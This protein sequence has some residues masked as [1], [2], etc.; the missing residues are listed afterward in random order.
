MIFEFAD[1]W[2]LLLLILVPFLLFLKGRA[3]SKAALRFPSTQ[4]AAQ[5]AAFV[6]S[7]PGRWR[8]ALRWLAFALLVVAMARPQTGEEL[9]RT[10]SSGIDMVIA[11]DL[12]SSMWAHD[13]EIDDRPVDRLTVVREVVTEFIENR[14]NDRIGLI[15]FAAQPYMVSP[16][17]LNHD[18][19]LRRLD[20]LSIGEIEDGTAIGSAIGTATNRL[21]EIPA[22]SKSIILLTDGANNRGRIEP[23][24]AAE[25]AKA[26]GIKIY[27]IGV[28]R[29]GIVPIP[30]RFDRNGQPVRQRDGRIYLRQARSD[31]DL[32]TLEEIADITSGH[33]FHA[34]N[35]EGLREVYAQIDAME[36]VE[37]EIEVRRL[38][39]EV[40]AYPLLLGLVLLLVDS[41]LKETRYRRLP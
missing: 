32:E 1:P 16:L 5:V 4:L 38:Y 24:P 23:V 13:F 20:A 30:A 36:T 37:V 29:G 8:A 22:D 12:S 15:A 6:R 41:V 21:R 10:T 25:A 40:F 27:S 7:R 33:Y 26:F 9:S 35:L 28:G 11:V 39:T 18:W 14:P 19:L 34:T 3:G 17:T 31:I 2:W